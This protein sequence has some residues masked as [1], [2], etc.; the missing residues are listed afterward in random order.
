MGKLF[1]K[2][3]TFWRDT[4]ATLMETFGTQFPMDPELSLLGNTTVSVILSKSQIKFLS[5]ALGVARK[6]T[7]I[8]CS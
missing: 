5:V 7:K 2:G 3:N 6:S 1:T 4:C 8:T